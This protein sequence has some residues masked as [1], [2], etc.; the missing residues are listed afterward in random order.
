MKGDGLKLLK[1]KSERKSGPRCEHTWTYEHTVYGLGDGGDREGIAA[2]RQC[3]DCGIHELC[4]VQ[5]PTWTRNV[6]GFSLPDLR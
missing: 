6:K 3:R 4:K 1:A 5:R 2:H